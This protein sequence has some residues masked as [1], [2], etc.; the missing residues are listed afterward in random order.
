MGKARRKIK[1]AWT[2]DGRKVAGGTMIV[3][4]KSA[5]TVPSRLAIKAQ[6]TDRPE[7]QRNQD[8]G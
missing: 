4:D 2:S 5:A 1:P 6:E 8:N 7:E 3:K